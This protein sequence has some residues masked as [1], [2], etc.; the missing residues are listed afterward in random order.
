MNPS[1]GN[2]VGEN[3][4]FERGPEEGP[5]IWSSPIEQDGAGSRSGCV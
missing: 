4:E 2:S 3:P 5:S 1:R